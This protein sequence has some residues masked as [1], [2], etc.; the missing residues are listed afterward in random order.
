MRYTVVQLHRNL[1]AEGTATASANDVW[2][3]V[4][5]S[6]STGESY[7]LALYRCRSV[8]DAQTLAAVLNG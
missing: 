5:T 3:V 2:L 7:D 1:I 6:P 8:V 4:D